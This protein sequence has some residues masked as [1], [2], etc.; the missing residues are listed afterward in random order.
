MYHSVLLCLDANEV[1]EMWFHFLES[2]HQKNACHNASQ[3]SSFA[4]TKVHYRRKKMTTTAKPKY[5]YK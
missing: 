3:D 1:V 2:I 4:I 5:I